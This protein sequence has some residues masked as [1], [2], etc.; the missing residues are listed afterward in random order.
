LT[1]GYTYVDAEVVDDTFIPGTPGDPD[2]ILV[3]PAGSP[4]PGTA[5]HT[6]NLGVVFSQPLGSTMTWRS[7]LTGFYQS[8][9]WN[10]LNP[11][12]ANQVSL[13]AFS[14]WNLT[15]GLAFERWD[16]TLFVRNLFNEEGIT[17][18]T[19]EVYGPDPAENYY[20]SGAKD[21]IAQPRTIGMQ[22]ALKF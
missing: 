17:A 10:V 1:L 19:R 13:D 3:A 7:T 15:T 9:M 16:V 14:L 2:P 18:R 4:L 5:E 11:N 21:F 20:G 6:A 12:S 22:L 8:E